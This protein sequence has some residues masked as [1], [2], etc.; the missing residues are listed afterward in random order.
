MRAVPVQDVVAVNVH[1]HVDDH[2]DVDFDLDVDLDGDDDVDR[3]TFFDARFPLP[4]T[5]P[6]ET[7]TRTR[8]G[9]GAG[10]GNRKPEP[11]PHTCHA[12]A[13]FDPP[14]TTEK[15]MS[16]SWDPHRYASNARFVAELGLPVLELL[17]PK[18]GERVLDL[19]CGDGA[20]TLE[21]VRRGCEVV[22]VDSSPQQIDA[23]RKLGLSAQLMNAERLEFSDEFDAVFSNAVLHWSKRP[24]DVVASVHRALVAGG[25][26]VAELG[27]SGCIAQIRAALVS[28]LDR[29]GI[30][31]EASVPWYFPTPGDYA[32][33][34]EKGGF[35]VDSMM[36]FPRP[37][38]LPGDVAGWLETFA[39]SFTNALAEADRAAYLQEVRADLET[40]LRDASG[41]WIADYVRLRFAATKV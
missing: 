11:E 37:T 30:D 27:G 19:G 17:A 29:R 22:G 26:F 32:T 6:P 3:T 14:P 34:L 41:T 25:R 8:T 13:S 24:D 23:A 10:A 5:G 9:A 4:D 18:P 36:L 21:L 33:R 31:G 35:R 16:Q 2:V 40:K 38:P 7:G 28:A 12:P 15:P 20:L 1:V 39:E